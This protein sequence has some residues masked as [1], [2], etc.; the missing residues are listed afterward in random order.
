LGKAYTYLRMETPVESVEK[1]VLDVSDLEEMFAQSGDVE[2]L[3]CVVSRVKQT[4]EALQGVP[5][6]MKKASKKLREQLKLVIL[7]YGEAL[8][9]TYALCGKVHLLQCQLNGVLNDLEL[10]WEAHSQGKTAAFNDIATSFAKDLQQARDLS[11]TDFEPVNTVFWKLTHDIVT[12]QNMAAE[13]KMN[14]KSQFW[15]FLVLAAGAAV[16]CYFCSKVL[17]DKTSLAAQ[18]CLSAASDKKDKTHLLLNYLK[19]SGLLAGA[20]SSGAQAVACGLVAKRSRAVGKNCEKLEEKLGSVQADAHTVKMLLG[21][22]KTDLGSAT[23]STEYVAKAL[24]PGFLSVIQQSGFKERIQ[25]SRA[26]LE[27]LK[28]SNKALKDELSVQIPKFVKEFIPAA[29]G[30]VS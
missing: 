24:S 25:D 29:F 1:E 28:K 8:E 30:L 6:A 26:E 2:L 27:A 4:Y 14:C 10:L 13:E 3:M 20:L 17:R 15:K 11:D 23:I 21:T 5:Q 22:M 16:T 18:A 9:K 12:L 19:S 7:Q